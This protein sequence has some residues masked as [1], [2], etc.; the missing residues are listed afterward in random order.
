[1]DDNVR[2]RRCEKER[3]KERNSERG[4]EREERNGKLS[5]LHRR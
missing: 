2:K 1:M 3:M 4:S 5:L